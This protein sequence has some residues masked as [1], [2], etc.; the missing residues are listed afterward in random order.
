[1]ARVTIEDCLKKEPNVFKLVGIAAER[2]RQIALE[3]TDPVATTGK[4][5]KSTVTALREIAEGKIGTGEN[6]ASKDTSIP[7]EIDDF[8]DFSNNAES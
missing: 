8:L 6:Q 3:N 1:M 7:D 2:A 4:K 5:N